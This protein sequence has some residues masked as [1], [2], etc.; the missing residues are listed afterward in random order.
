[1][2]MPAMIASSTSAPDVI[3]WNAFSTAHTGPPFFQRIPLTSETT[4]GFTEPVRTAGACAC[5][6]FPPGTNEAVA[7]A[8][9]IRN[10]RRSIPSIIASSRKVLQVYGSGPPVRYAPRARQHP[11]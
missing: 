5:P 8:P 1:M 4:T 3:I 10:C 7:S 2:L 11:P 6:C 9:P